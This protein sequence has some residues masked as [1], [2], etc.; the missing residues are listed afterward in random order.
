MAGISKSFNPSVNIERD[1]D[2]D[3]DYVV[4]PNSRQI[5]SQLVQYLDSGV[6]SFTIIGSY[7]TGKSSF[8]VALR[9]NL[10]GDTLYFEPLNGEFTS[11]D[12]FEFDYIVG[13]Y[14]SLIDEMCNHF[15]LENGATEKEIL[16]WIDKKHKKFKK[17]GKFWFIV[18][19]EFG[20]HLEY[21]A[22]ENPEKELYFIQLLSEYVNNNDK[23]L[24]FVT[25]LHQAFDSYAHGLDLQQRKEWDKVRG[26]LKEL[27]FN[28]PVEQLLYIASEYL[29]D[30]EIQKDSTELEELLKAIDLAKAFPLKNDLT[31]DLAQSLFPIDPLSGAI[32]SLALQKYGQNERSLF[33]F[34]QSDEFLGINNYDDTTN[35]FY[36][37]HCVYDYL[38]HNHHSYLSSKYNPHYV[39]WNAL[40]KALERIESGF[41]E[42][43]NS[44]KKVTKVIG[45]LN[46]FATEGAEIDNDFL[47]S[48]AEISIGLENAEDLINKLV[49]KQII[50]FRSYKK[51]YVLFEGTDFDIEHEL[52]QASSKID[53]VKDVVTPLRSYFKFPYLPAKRVYYETGTPRF[54][55]FILTEKPIKKIPEQP[56][57]GIINL[58]FDTKFEKVKSDSEEVDLPILYG[59]FNN[60]AD[61]E[62]Q[63]FLIEKTKY[64]IKQVQSDPVAERELKQLEYSQVEELK[65]M[66]LANVYESRGGI[67]WA[68]FG[69]QLDIV[70]SKL[71]NNELSNIAQESYAKT[72]IFSNELINKEKVSPA[73]YRPRKILL[74][75]LVEDVHEKDLGFDS[76]TFPPEKTIYLSLLQ[77]SGIHRKNGEK[78]ELGP[79]EPGKGFDELWKTCEEF[80]ESTKS[81]KRPLTDLI[82]TLKRPPF[83]LKDGFLELWI[84]IFLI[85]KDNDYALFQEE[86]YIP[87]LSYDIINLVLRDSRLFE[88]KAYH[89]SDVKKKIFSKYRA[90]HDQDENADFSNVSFVET[91]RPFLLVYNGLNEYGRN[92]SKISQPSQKLRDAIKTATEPEKA[93]FEDFPL[94]LGYTNLENLQSEKVLKQYVHDLDKAIEEIKHSYD[95]LI[96]RIEN[97]L[98]ETLDIDVNSAFKDYQLRIKS[99]Y[100]S[101]KAYK[102]TPYQKKLLDR[103]NSPLADREKWLSS[104]AF[105][106][107]DKPLTKM[108]DEE[109][110]LLLDKLSTRLEELDNLVE[111]SSLDFDPKKQDAYRF[112]I[113]TLRKESLDINVIADKKK[114]EKASNRMSKIKELLTDDK[115]TNMA[116]LLKILEELD[117]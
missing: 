101:I 22:K 20:K 23:N 99:R 53:A 36:N 15:D 80:F 48:Y 57:D 107:L 14:G 35:P 46:I 2:R 59:V 47:K 38:I 102:L 40:K 98:L 30:V 26:R 108:D 86:A 100:E 6:H 33:T 37:L 93:F 62:N 75:K 111:L 44:L 8:L 42:D 65:E 94:A 109:E 104:I 97:C 27:T 91:I 24:F 21:A 1:L 16:K 12:G 28:E 10:I 61:I 70:D 90:Y 52:H 113:Q 64:V 45:L 117:K 18:I 74:Q 32:L 19:D 81:G 77:Q 11:I 110:P 69:R 49:K 56:I 106:I 66:V 31:L 67:E 72:P 34:L 78:W 58:V 3:F 116:V 115:E 4:T 55:E 95:A 71:L 9:K 25:T 114:I 54:F 13:K 41:E 68:Y 82:N 7:G 89:I 43:I 51:Q 105:A 17:E 50:R 92:T 79:P 84:P 39:Q 83:G 29:S 73:I 112:K 103:L 87:E 85:I 60:T 88:I 63:I 5:Y 76:E 96:D